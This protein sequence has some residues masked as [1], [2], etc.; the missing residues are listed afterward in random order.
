[1]AALVFSLSGCVTKPPAGNPPIATV[2]DREITADEF[3]LNYT[4][5]FGNLR[6]GDNPRSNYL[7]LMMKEAALSVEAE[8]L[9]LDT[10]VV[11]RNAMRTLRE[12]LLIE[13]VFERKVLDQIV[14]S[15]DEMRAEM[16]RDAVQFRFRFLPAFSRAEAEAIRDDVLARG[17]ESALNTRREAFRELELPEAELHSPFVK[18]TDIDPWVLQAIRDL[19]VGS[20]SIPIERDGMWF[21]FEV[22]DFKRTPITPDVFSEQASSYRKIIYNRKALDGATEFV[23]S[24]MEP[25]NVVTRRAAF[26]TLAASLFEWYQWE[27]PAQPLSSTL[28]NPTN[29]QPFVNR[30]R[31]NKDEVLVE[32]DGTAWTIGDFLEH[33]TPGRYVIRGR[34]RMTFDA[35]LVDVVGL[36]VRDAILLEIA[37]TENIASDEGFRLE[38]EQWRYKWLYRALVREKYG[39]EPDLRVV[40]A[41][42]DSLLQQQNVN[43]DFDRLNALNLSSVDRDRSTVQLRKSNSNKP[44]FPVV[45]PGW[46]L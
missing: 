31:H 16:E 14:V 27:T 10:S 44:P 29:Q 20:P 5:G 12:E 40:H 23:G 7:A 28:A 24:I 33:F 34:D 18:A 43:V 41:Y 22:A 39:S 26:E 36:V 37:Q 46:A 3:E 15:E 1:M 21:V 32:F 13:K 9:R 11:V 42:A 19:P 35:R 8:R 30:L 4:F 25:L 6:R 45:D 17:F 38:L 2:G